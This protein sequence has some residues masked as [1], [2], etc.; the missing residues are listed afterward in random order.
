MF[1]RQKYFPPHPIQMTPEEASDFF[2]LSQRV[3]SAVESHLG[4][5]ACTFCVQDGADA[6]QTVAHVH[7]HVLPRRPGDFERNDDIYDELAK[8][9]KGE[10]AEKGWRS[11]EVM[12][13]EAEELRRLF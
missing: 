7:A 5:S 11:L 12:E 6:G 13:R 1:Y 9:D 10:Q 8:H 2:L 3:S 4:A